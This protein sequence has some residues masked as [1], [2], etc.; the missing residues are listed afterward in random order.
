MLQYTYSSVRLY[1]RSLAVTPPMALSVDQMKRD[2]MVCVNVLRLSDVGNSRAVYSSWRSRDVAKA[3]RSCLPA[4]P[5][6]AHLQR[7]C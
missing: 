4:A 7:H 5:M 6:T 1:S 2:F 3:E